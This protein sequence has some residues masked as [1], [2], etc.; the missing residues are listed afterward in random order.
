MQMHTHP[1][2]L[3]CVWFGAWYVVRC[4][5]GKERSCLCPSALNIFPMFMIGYVALAFS[6]L[7]F[8]LPNGAAPVASR[9][10]HASARH[11]APLAFDVFG[12][13]APDSI[14]PEC[15][16]ELMGPW[17]LKSS[18]SGMEN[19]WVE[20]REEG[21]C[22]CSSRIGKG[23]SW[24]AM[25]KAGTWIL[26]FTVSDKMDRPVSFEGNV[27]PD[28]TRGVVI[29]GMVLGPPK[30]RGATAAQRARG[31]QVGEFSGYLLS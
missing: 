15:P 5:C 14:K 31:V 11:L 6:T 28:D 24:S 27:K 1:R 12:E 25:R 26:T 7:S 8:S 20:L 19:I 17:E 3:V 10:L 23:K 30:L 16:D 18:V 2:S 21:A 4:V 22:S 9:V 29:D 13:T